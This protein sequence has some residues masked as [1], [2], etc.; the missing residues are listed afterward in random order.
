RFERACLQTLLQQLPCGVVLV[1][2]PTGRTVL[3]SDRA[4]QILGFSPVITG[5]LSE[6][7]W[8][9]PHPD[10]RPYRP[11][12]W[13]LTR[14]LLSGEQIRDERL[15]LVR[16]DGATVDVALSCAPI[17]GQ[18]G[19]IVAALGVFDVVSST[20]LAVVPQLSKAN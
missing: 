9:E 2:A 10:G 8:K 13:P 15:T 6:A 12:D 11:E 3:A 20:T 19:T 7:G 18:D 14:S 4:L 17:R 5:Q 1:E 16:P